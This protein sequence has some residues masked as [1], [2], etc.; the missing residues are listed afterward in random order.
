MSDSLCT[1]MA[2][3]EWTPSYFIYIFKKSFFT[4]LPI[5]ID[6]HKPM[7]KNFTYYTYTKLPSI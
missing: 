4:L 2:K 3:L 1:V 7:N 5:K 6:K